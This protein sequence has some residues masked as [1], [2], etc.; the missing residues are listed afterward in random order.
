MS[1]HTCLQRSGSAI[2]GKEPV[3]QGRAAAYLTELELPA[4]ST[5]SVPGITAL[6]SDYI[7]IHYFTAL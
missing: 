4:V 1:L 2:K 3:A 5:L 7:C 6:G